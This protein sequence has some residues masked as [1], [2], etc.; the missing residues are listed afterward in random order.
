MWQNLPGEAQ[1]IHLFTPE[2]SNVLQ[3][4][5][6][7]A[8]MNNLLNQHFFFKLLTGIW[9]RSHLQESGMTQKQ[10]CES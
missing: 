2:N 1:Q 7:T 3:T 8:T 6:K 10:L 9:V 4:K 5:V